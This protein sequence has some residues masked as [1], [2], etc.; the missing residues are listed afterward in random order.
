MIGSVSV[1]PLLL[2]PLRFLLSISNLPMVP[3]FSR[4]LTARSCSAASLGDRRCTADWVQDTTIVR[5]VCYQVPWGPLVG[6]HNKLKKHFCRSTNA[7]S[8]CSSVEWTAGLEPDRVTLKVVP[9]FD[10]QEPTVLLVTHSKQNKLA[11][12]TL[13]SQSSAG[14]AVLLFICSR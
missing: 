10:S 13:I 11:A 3:P 14:G 5:T 6:T 8:G 7:C 9:M 12:L 2:L 4:K 1:V